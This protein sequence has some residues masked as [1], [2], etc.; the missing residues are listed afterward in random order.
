MALSPPPAAHLGVARDDPLM[1]PEPGHGRNRAYSSS[2][3]GY[4]ND[5]FAPGSSRAGSMSSPQRFNL[6]GMRPRGASIIH[7]PP[8]TIDDFGIPDPFDGDTPEGG[9]QSRTP[10][11]PASAAALSLFGRDTQKAVVWPQRSREASPAGSRSG[12]HPGSRAGSRAPSRSASRMGSRAGSLVREPVMERTGPWAPALIHPSMFLDLP[13]VSLRQLGKEG[14]ADLRAHVESHA[15]GPAAD[16]AQ[17][18][19]SAAGSAGAQ[20]RWSMGRQHSFRHGGMSRL[21]YL[22]EQC[23]SS[24]HNR[25][26]PPGELWQIM[27]G[28]T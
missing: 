26:P 8:M 24:G 22:C 7:G 20:R 12:S 21:E 6:E 25:P 15:V 16:L 27:Q 11:L 9:S 10:E 14:D 5:L 2:S 23:R 18:V 13:T 28:I 1:S 19:C 3:T 4:S 17:Q